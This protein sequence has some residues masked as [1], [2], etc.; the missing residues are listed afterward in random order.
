MS[1]VI[2]RTPTET[3]VAAMEEAETANLRVADHGQ[4][5]YNAE[6]PLPVTGYRGVCPAHDTPGSYTAYVDYKK[7]R[8]QCGTFRSAVD[9]AR[10]RDRLALKLQGEFATLNF[11]RSDYSEVDVN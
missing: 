1:D 11:P 2:I 6:R 3:I 4:Q 8:H 9:A 7:V 5:Q 10:A